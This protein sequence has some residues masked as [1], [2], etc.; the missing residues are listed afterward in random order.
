M[1]LTGGILA[2]KPMFTP[3]VAWLALVLPGP[4]PQADTRPREDHPPGT[5][6]PSGMLRDA[7]ANR[8][9]AAFN[10]CIHIGKETA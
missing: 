5:L 10:D 8:W 6:L 1:Y 2:Q 3:K 7:D 4:T 9:V